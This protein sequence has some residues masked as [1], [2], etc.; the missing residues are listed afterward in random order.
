MQPYYTSADGRSTLYHGDCRLVLPALALPPGSVGLVLTDPPYSE[1]THTGARTAR[2]YGFSRGET[3]SPLI[4]FAP[5]GF[6][7]I[8]V[9]LTEAARAARRWVISFLDWR[10]LAWLADEPP[11]GLRFV[12]FGIWN[13][14]NGAPQFIGDRPAAGWEA[15]GIFRAAGEAAADTQEEEDDAGWS[16]IGIFHREGARLRWNG[17][18]GRA[19]WTYP[20]VPGAT[21]PSQK[22]VALLS[23]LL[24]LFSEP[25]DLVLDPFAG[26]G[27][28]AA[29][30][31]ATG[32]R[33]IS[34][35]LDEASCALIARRLLHG[36]AA[37]RRPAQGV[38]PL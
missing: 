1:A 7:D 36:D 8:R 20:K 16:A 6:E 18:G 26:S 10:H 29:A 33:C 17:G 3:T 38:M 2:N 14:P 13:K 23:H 19:V 15:V 9:V 34:I 37:A 12:R 30:C 21:H 24:E 32:R 5:L 28:T 35:E 4:T 25:D 22:P 27:S 11:E 31:A